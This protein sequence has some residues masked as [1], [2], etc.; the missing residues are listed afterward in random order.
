MIYNRH[1]VAWLAGRKA[2]VKERWGFGICIR[3]MGRVGR[4]AWSKNFLSA[5]LCSFEAMF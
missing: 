2:R 5:F 4:W 3:S 1:D